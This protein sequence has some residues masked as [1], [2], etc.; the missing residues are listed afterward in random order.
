MKDIIIFVE[1]DH[2]YY[3]NGE[4]LTSVSSFFENYKP[5][6]NSD[7][8]SSR[9]AIKE[10]VGLP[11]YKS[12]EE[13]T[14]L[15]EEVLVSDLIN[16]LDNQTLELFKEKKQFYLDEWD[17]SGKD[18]SE[19]GT[20]LHKE[21]ELEDYNR[22]YGINPY[23]GKK[24]N[25]VVNPYLPSEDYANCSINLDMY[26][27]EDGYYPELVIHN[28]NNDPEIDLQ[29]CGQSDRVFIETIGDKRF[30]D[31]DDYKFTNKITDK[32]FFDIKTRKF[33]YMLPP[34]SHLQNC[35]KEEYGMKISLYAW[36]LE[37]HGFIVRNIGLTHMKLEKDNSITPILY[38]LDYR[39][40][41]VK[42]IIQD[43][44]NSNIQIPW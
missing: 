10:I 38:N 42:D 29:L 21:Y 20:L 17:K 11:A 43:Y 8:L 28:P 18:S 34:L 26:K 7:F 6:F 19:R 25:V 33:Q 35:N 24:Y 39:K 36:M 31:I 23:D 16:K 37:Q 32:G 15:E 5:K 13:L 41:E 30:V 1:K 3:L 27:L 40:T 12:Y 4:R 44:C 9:K 22:G 14:G 2:S